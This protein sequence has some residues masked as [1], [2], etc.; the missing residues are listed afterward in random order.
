M[1]YITDN[2]L[3]RLI[4]CELF[5]VNCLVEN[6][7]QKQVTHMIADLLGQN[8]QSLRKRLKVQFDL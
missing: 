4:A 2:E 3:K 6:R 1:G 7:N 5:R 8:L